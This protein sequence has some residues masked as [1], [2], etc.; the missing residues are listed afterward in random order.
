[1]YSY[2]CSSF[3]IYWYSFWILV[4]PRACLK[5][6]IGLIKVIIIDNTIISIIII[7]L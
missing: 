3:N 6:G 5:G 7:I 4:G 2:A 1:M